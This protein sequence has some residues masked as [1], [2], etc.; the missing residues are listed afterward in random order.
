MKNDRGVVVSTLLSDSFQ[1]T[2]NLPLLLAHVVYDVA[3]SDKAKVVDFGYTFC[4]CNLSSNMILVSLN[5]YKVGNLRS[6]RYE[7]FWKEIKT[8]TGKNVESPQCF[9]PL[10]NYAENTLKTSTINFNTSF[11]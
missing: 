9:F 7:S 3:C 6:Y 11:C 5:V 10:L 4:M 1:K 2:D 8:E